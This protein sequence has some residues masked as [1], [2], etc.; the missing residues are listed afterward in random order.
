[1]KNLVYIPGLRFHVDL[2]LNHKFNSKYKVFV[3]TTSPKNKFIN[4]NFTY[5]F[6]PQFFK[7]FTKLFKLKSNN[8][9]KLFDSF[10]FQFISIIILIFIKPNIIHAWG[11]YA[12]LPFKFF[13]N[14][15]KIIERSSTY[16]SLQLDLINSELVRLNLKPKTVKYIQIKNREAEYA[17]SDKIIISSEYVRSSFPPNLLNKTFILFP[18]S[19]KKFQYSYKK[20]NNKKIVIGYIG[21]NVIVKGLPWLLNYFIKQNTDFELLLRLNKSDYKDYAF[22]N[23][24]IRNNK[25][26]KISPTGD[27]IENFYQSI[28]LLIQPTIDDGFPMTT[29]EALSCGVPVFTSNKSGSVEVIKKILPYNI[30]DNNEDNAIG[31]LLSNMDAVKLKQQSIIIKNNFEEIYISIIKHNEEQLSLIHEKSSFNSRN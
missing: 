12:Y 28:D 18:V 30:F 1:M 27:D 29:I 25:N 16:D 11:G 7:I 3:L 20:I 8:L 13:K 31:C 15:F 26:I 4:K 6:I 17:L 19:S 9:M 5:I 24:V 14:S 22:I 10:L 21:G 2:Y 23:S